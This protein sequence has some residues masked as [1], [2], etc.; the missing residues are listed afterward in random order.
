MNAIKKQSRLTRNHIIEEIWFTGYSN[1]SIHQ[2][3]A[4]EP[5]SIR[6]LQQIIEG[7]YDEGRERNRI[8]QDVYFDGTSISDI[9]AFMSSPQLSLRRVQSITNKAFHRE[10]A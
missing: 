2:L 1:E 10:L 4:H 3:M 5:L 9:H 7:P 8:I 6:R